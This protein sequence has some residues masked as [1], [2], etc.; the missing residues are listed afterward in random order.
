MSVKLPAGPTLRRG[1]VGACPVCGGRRLFRRW[2]HMVED[3]PRCG[4]HFERIE[5]HWLGSLGLNTVVTFVL[6]FAV[7][8]VG[9]AVTVPDVPV[10]PLVLVGAGV[11][12]LFPLLFFPVSRTLWT[13]ID[14]LARPP[15]A[16]ELA[17]TRP[18]EP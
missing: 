5:G 10:L 8:V 3:C 11:G 7:L 14:L 18:P 13:A 12:L 15:D 4:F 2:F 17:P 1:L 16:S 6:L 9:L